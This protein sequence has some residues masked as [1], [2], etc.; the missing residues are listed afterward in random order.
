ME[1]QTYEIN[2]ATGTCRECGSRVDLL[3]AYMGDLGF[4]QN[5]QI[6]IKTTDEYL[7]GMTLDRLRAEGFD[8]EAIA[9][10]VET[11][12]ETPVIDHF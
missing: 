3:G 4:C 9:L 1:M 12:M 2:V 11:Q 7:V 10:L 6:E 5:C 8:A